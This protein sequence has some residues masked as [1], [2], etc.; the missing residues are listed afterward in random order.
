MV[1]AGVSAILLR[2]R[3]GLADAV[4]RLVLLA[5]CATVALPAISVLLTGTPRSI[6]IHPALPG[7]PWVV[8]LDPLAAWFVLPLCVVAAL[9]GW[10]G[11]RY[12]ADERGHRSVAAAHAGFALLVSALLSVFLAQ[13]AVC[14]LVAWEL[15]AISAFLLI[16]FEH[17]R[18]EA[19]TAGLVYLALTHLGTL[20]LIGMFLT[21]GR[22]TPDLRFTTLAAAGPTLPFGGAVVL[23]LAV[24]GFGI[25][26]GIFPLHFWLPPAHAASPSHGSALLSGIMIKT[27]IYG[28]V[29][30][31][32]L[33][34]SPPLWFGWTLL[35]L[36]LATAVLGVVWALGQHDLKR[37]LAFS[38]VE[39]IGIIVA[40][41]G[42]G[43]LGAGYG[44]PVVAVLGY[45]GALLHA[46][47]HSLIKSLLFLGA[48]AVV[49]ATGTR[50]IDR[51]GGVARSMPRTAVAFLIGALAIVGLPPLNGFISEW[52]TVQ[53]LLEAG[54]GAGPLRF[55]AAAVAPIGLVAALALA[56]F[57]RALALTFLGTERVAPNQPL[58]EVPMGML[59]PMGIAAAICLLVGAVPSL[60]LEPFRSVLASLPQADRLT[61]SFG[62]LPPG[63][64]LTVAWLAAGVVVVAL[65]ALTARRRRGG[66]IRLA[67]TWGCAFP[68]P[69]ARMQYTAS[70]FSAPLLRSAAPP[71]IERT[72]GGGTTFRTI[73]TDPIY[74][75]VVESLWPRV[76]RA[77]SAARPIQRGR[78][79]TYLQ[80]III[81]LVL[82]LALLFV[83]EP[84]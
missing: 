20:A 24:V 79:T 48:G 39:N 25:K 11:V 42:A 16:V 29:R 7:G 38:S 84:P 46:F 10:Y 54:K 71:V 67:P 3:E 53:G 37:L 15:M 63:G 50:E 8:G 9:T 76:K 64:P 78:V 23:G 66:D 4:F 43:S 1:A 45:G 68:E 51:M 14:F 65:V 27:G 80:F 40:G 61:S 26:A 28:I 55:L 36:G 77:A 69:R 30:V 41:L 60:V 17:E 35:L 70:S 22:A 49:R 82:L 83:S 44:N 52:L 74:R 47:N 5:G 33:V 31:M 56:T 12:L 34:G 81:T 6:E 57:T 75:T 2:G 58:E 72:G 73:P 32:I 62:A 21:W 19:R 18:A 59:A 13:S